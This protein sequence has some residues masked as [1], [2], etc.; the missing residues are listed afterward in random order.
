LSVAEFGKDGGRTRFSGWH[1]PW[2]G[3]IKWRPRGRT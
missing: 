3:W 2:L 1:L